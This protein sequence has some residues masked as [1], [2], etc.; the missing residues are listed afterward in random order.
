MMILLLGGVA[1]ILVSITRMGNAAK[2]ITSVSITAVSL[3]A[4]ITF[5]QWSNT[6]RHETVPR[7]SDSVYTPPS[8][9]ILFATRMMEELARRNPDDD[10][11]NKLPSNT[12]AAAAA[13]AAHGVSS[14]I[15]KGIKSAWDK[16]SGIEKAEYERDAAAKT[17][18]A[19]EPAAVDTSE[20]SNTLG[21]SEW[22][23]WG[24]RGS[25][26]ISEKKKGK[27]RMR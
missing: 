14:E 4:I 22:S 3:L 7:K 27:Q 13:A 25:S 6:E 18:A 20:D 12:T 16:L 2:I 21:R 23:G 19:A 5:D 26:Y 9:Y 24:G 15:E 8:G 1:I 17:S 11:L 10:F